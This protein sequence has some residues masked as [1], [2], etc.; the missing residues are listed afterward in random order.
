M[1]HFYHLIDL[2]LSTRS[3]LWINL[4]YKFS[5]RFMN[6]KSFKSLRIIINEEIVLKYKILY[7]NILFYILFIAKRSLLVYEL[8][9]EISMVHIRNIGPGLL[10]PN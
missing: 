1:K 8:G 10:H 6:T 7:Q 9:K 3:Q 4:Y 2:W 5:F